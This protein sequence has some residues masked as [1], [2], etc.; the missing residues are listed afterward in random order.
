MAITAPAFTSISTYLTAKNFSIDGL[1]RA[2]MGV[3]LGKWKNGRTG[4]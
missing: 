3:K 1:E 2:G 4:K